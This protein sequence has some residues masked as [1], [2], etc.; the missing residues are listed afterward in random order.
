MVSLSVSIDTPG[1]INWLEEYASKKN[2]YTKGKLSAGKAAA[3]ILT[4]LYEL[5]RKQHG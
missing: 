2:L 5:E 1:L 3:L 4:E